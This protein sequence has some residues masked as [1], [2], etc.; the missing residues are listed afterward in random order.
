[1]ANVAPESPEPSERPL[2]AGHLLVAQ[3]EREGVRRVYGVP[4]ESFLDV[5][6]GLHD[7]PIS[8]VV[9]RHE[10]GAG[11]MALAEGRLTGLPGVAMVTRGPGAANAFIAVHTAYQDATPM[12]LFVGLVPVPD[13][14]RDSFQEFDLTGWFGSTAKKVVMLDDPT[15]AARVVAESVHVARSGRPGPVVIGLPEDVLTL[16]AGPARPVEPLAVP[17]PRAAEAELKE[18]VRRLEHARRPLIVVGGE[19]W[20][21]ESGQELMR[22]ATRHSIPVLA[23]FRAYDAV[24][25]DLQGTGAYAGSLGY[26][27]GDHAARLL[28]EA[29]LTV[30]LGAPRG[31]VLSD[32]YTRGLDSETVLVLPGDAQGHSGRIDQFVSAHAPSFV[33]D[34][35][36]TPASPDADVDWFRAAGEAH[37]HFST[38]SPEPTNSDDDTYVDLTAVMSVLRE[39]LTPDTV[40][41][42]GAG[43]HALWPARHLPHRTPAS[44]V[45]PRNGA[46]GMGIPAAVAASLVFP[47]REVVSVA[48]DGCFLMNGQELATAVGHGAVFVALVV[49]NGCYATIREHQEGAYPGRPSGTRLTNPDFAAWAR[50]YGAYGESVTSHHDFRE[51][52]RRARAS[53]LPAVLHL[54]QDPAVR[55]P[56]TTA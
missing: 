21:A 54:I 14:G 34:L 20:T 40:I 50:S 13:R 42:Y 49:D 26:G 51:A 56:A 32:G 55:A 37:A 9:T 10:G 30:F 5:L 47:G 45:A 36:T 22:W 44:L 33:L 25:H 8:T 23:D 16:P 15:A 24:P 31:D 43:N 35:V 6:D 27:R 11:F 39:E 3:L 2:S 7:S 1:M 29:D 38:P 41:T 48:G 4:G 52:F 19:G 17:R 46:M 53:G 12:L 18:L 28:D